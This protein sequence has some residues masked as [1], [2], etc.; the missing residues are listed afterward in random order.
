MTKTR[1]FAWPKSRVTTKRTS[2]D[3]IVVHCAA[4]PEGKWFDAT[5]MDRM[6][7]QLGWAGIGYHYVIRLD[8][9]I[10]QGRPEDA[11][12]SHVAGYNSRALGI[13][14]IGGV[15]ADGKSPKDTRTPEQKAALRQLLTS[16]RAKHRT[17]IIQGHR[18][19]PK[20]AKACPSFD[21]KREYATL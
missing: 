18:D 3:Y 21:A 15:A 7:L 5:D 16:L 10:E 2:T 19:F 11:V 20:V 1:E 12:G 4:T 17:A 9:S 6:H 13:V 8:G 14:Y